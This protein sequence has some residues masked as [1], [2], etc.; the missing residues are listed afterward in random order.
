MDKDH[1]N[2]LLFPDDPQDIPHAVELIRAIICLTK[3]NPTKPPYTDHNGIPDVDTIIDFEAIKMLAQ[4][5]HH[6]LKPFVNPTLS[7][8]QQV[9]YISTCSHLL[10]CQYCL[11]HAAF[12]PNQ[13]Y[14]DITTAMKNIIFCIAK[15][16]WL[17]LSSKFLLLDV[18]TDQVEVLF[19]LI[20]MC[21]GHNSTVNYKQGIDCLCLA[22]NISDIYSRNPDLHHGHHQLNFTCSEHVDHINCGMWQG[23]TVVCNCNLQAAWSDRRAV[24]V[25]ILSTLPLFPEEYDFDRIFS[26]EDVDLMCVFGGGKYPSINQEDEGEDRSVLPQVDSQGTDTPLQLQAVDALDEEL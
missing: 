25:S 26:V 16:L 1:A 6:L 4:I 13:L 12:L 15:Q 21:S 14:Y 8:S 10:F 3:I 19:A 23:D 7:L 5:L 24:V 18:G 22:C 17:D 2:K 9:S 20:Q 11:N